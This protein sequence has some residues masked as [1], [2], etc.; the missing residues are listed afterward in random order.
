MSPYKRPLEHIVSSRTR[1]GLQSTREKALGAVSATFSWTDGLKD[2]LSEVNAHLSAFRDALY[3]HSVYTST[4]H[5]SCYLAHLTASDLLCRSG[6]QTP[7]VN[8]Y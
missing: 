8:S 7:S 4:G 5:C 2:G 1:A 3:H 6:F